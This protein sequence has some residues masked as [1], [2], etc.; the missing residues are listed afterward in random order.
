MSKKFREL[1]KNCPYQVTHPMLLFHHYAKQLGSSTYTEEQ[2]TWIKVSELLAHGSL[3]LSPLGLGQ[4]NT[5][6]Q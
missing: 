6:E 2:L 3:I 5:T 1:L 4:G